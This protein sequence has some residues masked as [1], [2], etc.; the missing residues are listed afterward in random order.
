MVAIGLLGKLSAKCL[1]LL[2]AFGEPT[3]RFIGLD[4]LGFQFL[5]CLLEH[6]LAI[7]KRQCVALGTGYL[8]FE[9]CAF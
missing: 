5:T 1:G 4:S 9:L 3:T 2:Y 7:A 8:G 6:P